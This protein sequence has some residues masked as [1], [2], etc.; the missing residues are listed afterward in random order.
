MANFYVKCEKLKQFAKQANSDTVI[1]PSITI[2]NDLIIRKMCNVYRDEAIKLGVDWFLWVKENIP[3]YSTRSAEDYRRIDKVLRIENQ[4][5]LDK[6]RYMYLF[7]SYQNSHLVAADVA[8]DDS[9]N[10]P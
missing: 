3:A 1:S 10:P 6:A 2:Q 5:L 7:L 4:H 9:K 8:T